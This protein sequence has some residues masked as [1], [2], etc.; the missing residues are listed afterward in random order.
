MAPCF[1]S[2]AQI[3]SS[4]GF[5]PCLPTRNQRSGRS[6]AVSGRDFGAICTSTVQHFVVCH[7]EDCG[8]DSKNEKNCGLPSVRKYSPFFLNAL[9]FFSDVRAGRLPDDILDRIF[10]L[11]DRQNNGNTDVIFRLRCVCRTFR[12]LLSDIPGT[13]LTSG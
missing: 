9:P 3:L 12:R 1:F 2:I 4:P 5:R 8:K 13:G 11:A 7:P 10:D 6:C